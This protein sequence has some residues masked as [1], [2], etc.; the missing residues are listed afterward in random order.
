MKLE[1]FLAQAADRGPC[2]GVHLATPSQLVG[3]PDIEV[4]TFDG[5]H[6]QT[7]DALYDGFA[8]AWL[9][10][11]GFAHNR[12]KDA[13]DDWMRDFDNLTN[14]ALDKPPASGYLTDITDAH[15][16]LGEQPDV[17]LGW[18]T[19]SPF[20]GI[21]TAMK[22]TRRRLSGCCFPLLLISSIKFANGVRIFMGR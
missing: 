16:L 10:P 15:L 14:P 17:F 1:E 11:A 7:L 19:Q 18:P 21:T 12:N 3:A 9:F 22:P 8:K 6:I 13:F 5:A 20:T 4:R 2:V